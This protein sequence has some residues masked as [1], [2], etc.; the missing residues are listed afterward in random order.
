M[1]KFRELL[2]W[3]LNFTNIG[4][5]CP[6]SKIFGAT[7][8]SFLCL[9]ICVFSPY[10][11]NSFLVFIFKSIWVLIL[12]HK[13][14][15]L[16]FHYHKLHCWLLAQP[17]AGFF[18]SL[19]LCVSLYEVICHI[20]CC[21]MVYQSPCCFLHSVFIWYLVIVDVVAFLLLVFIDRPLPS[22][23]YPFIFYIQVTV[24]Y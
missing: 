13:I 6:L 21:F 22:W 4:G 1:L 9:W 5:L 3:L 24:L 16:H 17:V 14:S 23:I 15:E 11:G 2:I 7:S 12:Q 8:L 20:I 10:V 19:S 18:T